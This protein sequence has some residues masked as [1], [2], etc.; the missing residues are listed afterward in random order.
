MGL[1]P[2]ST[3][4]V[5]EPQLVPAL[6]PLAYSPNSLWNTCPR[7]SLTETKKERDIC[8]L[9]QGKE[10]RNKGTIR[11]ELSGLQM[12]KIKAHGGEMALPLASLE[13]PDS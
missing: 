1:D 11:E 4:V 10:Q 13:G 2:A 5:P 3:W 12:G 7:K 6:C 8:L 9:C